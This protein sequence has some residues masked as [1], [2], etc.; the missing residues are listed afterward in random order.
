M[1]AT[2][3]VSPY[4]SALAFDYRPAN[5]LVGAE[6]PA[7]NRLS[8]ALL[9]ASSGRYTPSVESGVPIEK[10]LPHQY[11]FPSLLQRQQRPRRLG[12]F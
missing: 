5:L 3:A 12:G 8:A 7:L 11:P 9:M 4:A 10:D 2:L 6:H 1:T